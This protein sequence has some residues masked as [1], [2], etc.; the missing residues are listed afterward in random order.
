[1][2]SPPESNTKRPPRLPKHGTF[3]GFVFDYVREHREFTVKQFKDDCFKRW[4]VADSAPCR[5]LS[6]LRRRGLVSLAYSC[7]RKY[8]VEWVHGD[9]SA[10]Q[11]LKAILAEIESRFGAAIP[12]ALSRRSIARRWLLAGDDH[13]LP[14]TE[15]AYR[16]AYHYGA[17]I[18]YRCRHINVEID[19]LIDAVYLDRLFYRLEASKRKSLENI[20]R[21]AAYRG[22]H[23]ALVQSDK[24]QTT[25]HLVRWIAAVTE[26]KNESA[27]GFSSPAMPA[28]VAA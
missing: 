3:A 14:E 24:C 25:G 7:N 5:T 13:A 8:F 28:E 23:Q 19:D 22:L 20:T 10:R 1:M 18:G 17:S 26:W 2:S 21:Q 6:D 9:L 12:P 15:A 16:E 4:M 27:D 11:Q